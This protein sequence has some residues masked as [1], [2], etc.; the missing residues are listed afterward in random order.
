MQV[1]EKVL[2]TEFPDV[3]CVPI[4][5]ALCQGLCYWELLSLVIFLVSPE[6]VPMNGVLSYRI[7]GWGQSSL[8]PVPPLLNPSSWVR[9]TPLALSMT[10]L[11]MKIVQAQTVLGEL[12]ALLQG[13]FS[14]RD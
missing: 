9:L 12:L 8:S 11:N 2:L 6:T 10:S 1:C 3:R 4:H 14:N 7:F 13:W 5:I